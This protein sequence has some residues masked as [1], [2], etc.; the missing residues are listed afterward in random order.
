MFKIKLRSDF[1]SF[2][3]VSN[4]TL[5]EN[6]IVSR[7]HTMSFLPRPAKDEGVALNERGGVL[8]RGVDSADNDYEILPRRGPHL[9]I[10]KH[11][12]LSRSNLCSVSNE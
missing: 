7:L 2:A 8:A 6:C 9:I 1:F 5:F 3:I 11:P 4:E 10:Q 12:N